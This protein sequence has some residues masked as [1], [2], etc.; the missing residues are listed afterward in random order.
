MTRHLLLTRPVHARPQRAAAR[1]RAADPGPGDP[2]ARRARAFAGSI[3]ARLHARAAAFRTWAAGLIFAPCRCRRGN[4]AVMSALCMP[5]VVGGVALGVDSTYWYFRDLE[6]QGAADA[7]AYAAAIE[8]RAGF[9][10]AT[11]KAAAEREAASNGLDAPGGEL[12][13]TLP[14]REESPSVSQAVEVVLTEPQARFFSGL[15]SRSAVVAEARAV[16]IYDT[17][18]YACV[19]ALDPEA[20]AAVSMR[21]SARLTL[22]GCSVMANSLAA[23]AVDLGGAARLE[24]AC[25]ISGGGLST[26]ASVTLTECSRAV[27]RAPPVADPYRLVPEPV[28]NGGCRDGAAPVLEPGR[29]CR[30][31]NLRGEVHLEPGVY[32]LENGDFRVNAGAKITGDGVTIFLGSGVGVRLNGGAA[33]TLS[34]PTTGSYSGLLVFAQR[35]SLR[36]SHVFNGAAGSSLTGA[37]Y[38]SGQDVEYAGNFTGEGGCLRIVA[39]TVGWTGN[40]EIEA[41]CASRGMPALP[42]QQL[43]RIVG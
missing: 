17:A 37:L 15:F 31:L 3:E 25:L 12:T 39:G 21:G 33:I 28:P 10:E 19:I 36:Q 7:A 24:A 22:K 8:L 6:L 27:T 35:K 20:S 9:D 2:P 43:I 40:A 42:A 1:T 41:D 29:Y 26:T 16:A 14:S 4:V 13:V 32:H 34:A 30:G 23:D 11:A 38:M 18:S 5:V